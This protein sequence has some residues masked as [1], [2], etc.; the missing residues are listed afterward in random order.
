[1]LTSSPSKGAFCNVVLLLITVVEA[2]SSPTVTGISNRFRIDCKDGS[3]APPNPA[4]PNPLKDIAI[5]GL[6]ASSLLTLIEAIFNPVEEGL[7]AI[8]K[9]IESPALIAFGKTGKLLNTNWLLLAPEILMDDKERMPAP[10]FFTVTVRFI[11]VA[12]PETSLS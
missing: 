2:L 10:V 8:K 12:P 3:L 1:M 4:V 7:K 9:E 6:D 11:P 5:E